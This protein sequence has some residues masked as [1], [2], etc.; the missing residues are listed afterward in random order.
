MG[1]VNLILN[2]DNR[3]EPGGE[4][5]QDCAEGGCEGGVGEEGKGGVR[6]GEVVGR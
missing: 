2:L 1:E 5:T 4:D 3:E 6:E